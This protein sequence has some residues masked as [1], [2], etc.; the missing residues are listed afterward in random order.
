[1][2]VQRGRPRQEIPSGLKEAVAPREQ[3]RSGN[4]VRFHGSAD[5]DTEDRGATVRWGTAG[6]PSSFWCQTSA[7]PSAPNIQRSPP[8]LGRSSP[9]SDTTSSQPPAA[10]V[11]SRHTTRV[12][13]VFPT[14]L[15][16]GPSSHP[17][18]HKK[19]DA[20]SSFFL[21]SEYSDIKAHEV[22]GWTGPCAGS[23]ALQGAPR[24]RECES[25]S[26][27]GSSSYRAKL[28]RLTSPGVCEA[29]LGTS[30]RRRRGVTATGRAKDGDP[31]LL[32]PTT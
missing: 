3:L 9:C 14:N 30:S 1:M 24:A 21:F 29:G 18:R 31:P 8:W 7:P 20:I 26:L 16:L 12:T 32:S 25:A 13:S 15:D 27:K 22:L 2:R 4:Q 28:N 17:K 11:R 10:S 5:G 19:E 6:F 23:G